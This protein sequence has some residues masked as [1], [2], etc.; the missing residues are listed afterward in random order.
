MSPRSKNPLCKMHAFHVTSHGRQ[1]LNR[2]LLHDQ[3]HYSVV[4]DAVDQASHPRRPPH[5]CRSEY[6]QKTR[7][8]SPGIN[9]HGAYHA[10]ARQSNRPACQLAGLLDRPYTRRNFDRSQ[11]SQRDILSIRLGWS[12]QESAIAV[13]ANIPCHTLFRT[14]DYVSPL[15]IPQLWQITASHT[16]ITVDS[17]RLWQ[18]SSTT[19]PMSRSE[20]RGA[21]HGFNHGDGY[22]RRTKRSRSVCPCIHLRSGKVQLQNR[23][24]STS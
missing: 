15:S 17:W 14:G 20:S 13:A 22:L 11:R 3:P 18:T 12:Y 5:Q 2:L 10:S 9:T 1:T 21:Q 4:R 7:L 16:R 8:R 23:Q 24:D 6:P 19:Y